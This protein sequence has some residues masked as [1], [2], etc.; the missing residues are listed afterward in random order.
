LHGIVTRRD[1]IGIM[2][3][4]TCFQGPDLYR[5]I[6]EDHAGIGVS[7]RMFGRIVTEETASGPIHVVSPPLRP[8]TYDVVTN[9]S[10]DTARVLEILSEDLNK[11]P[12]D[13]QIIT[14]S[15]MLIDNFRLPGNDMKLY[16]EQLIRDAFLRS[17]VKFR[18]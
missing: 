13:S 9:P 4:L 15:S 11:V 12:S 16:Q 6:V 10:H 3:T 18:L 5:L 1:I 14:E 8:I 2:E 7:L 17:R